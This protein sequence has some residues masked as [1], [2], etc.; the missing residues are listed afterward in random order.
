M[1]L[2]AVKWPGAKPV[3]RPMEETHI[4]GLQAAGIYIL[5]QE[6]GNYMSPSRVLLRKLFR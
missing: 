2:W 4:A 3:Q 5:G 1:R 6:L